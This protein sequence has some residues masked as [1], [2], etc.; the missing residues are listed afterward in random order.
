ML[1]SAKNHRNYYK[2][3]YLGRRNPTNSSLNPFFK[4]FILKLSPI[5][6]IDILFINKQTN[7]TFP[8]SVSSDHC[9]FADANCLGLPKRFEIL[10]KPDRTFN[11]IECCG[12]Q[13]I[14]GLSLNCRPCHYHLQRFKLCVG[15]NRSGV[16]EHI[17]CKHSRY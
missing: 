1:Y 14:L 9:D 13:G 16:K 7:E 4:T 2:T 6:P 5:S 17:V 15:A 8:Y 12:D 11:F 10:R 3:M